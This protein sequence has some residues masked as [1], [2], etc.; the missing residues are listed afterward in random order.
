MTTTFCFL[1]FRWRKYNASLSSCNEENSET[2]LS[3]SDDA[4]TTDDETEVVDEAEATSAEVVPSLEECGNENEAM[5][6]DAESESMVN[7]RQEADSSNEACNS[8]GEAEKKGGLG[9]AIYVTSDIENNVSDANR[10]YDADDSCLSGTLDESAVDC[11]DINAGGSID[12]VNLVDGE[13]NMDSPKMEDS[14]KVPPSKEQNEA[15]MEE[16]GA[17]LS[18]EIMENNSEDNA[19]CVAVPQQESLNNF[20]EFRSNSLVSETRMLAAVT[21]ETEEELLELDGK[22]PADL[23]ANRS[24]SLEELK[25]RKWSEERMHHSAEQVY[26]SNE[27]VLRKG[28]LKKDR[29]L[30]DNYENIKMIAK[31]SQI[32]RLSKQEAI[33]EDSPVLDKRKS[34]SLDALLVDDVNRKSPSLTSS[35]LSLSDV[36]GSIESMDLLESSNS[37]LYIGKSTES[38]PFGHRASLNDITFT[39][40]DDGDEAPPMMKKIRSR[41]SFKRKSKSTTALDKKGVTSKDD[42]KIK[43]ISFPS[44]LITNLI[45]YHVKLSACQ[46]KCITY[47]TLFVM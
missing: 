36:H 35:Q 33:D 30:S 20:E 5:S 47:C 11:G 43:L 12:D 22:C 27:A 26:M 7:D 6:C 40:R 25:A 39:V 31:D 32:N 41:F 37:Q 3:E 8:G 1:A 4:E 9:E 16:N 44:F 14:S 15:G 38:G 34:K 13:R 21:E 29:P 19:S 46:L 10:H 42:G 28:I 18:T 2:K 17:V 45:M 24:H 23:Y